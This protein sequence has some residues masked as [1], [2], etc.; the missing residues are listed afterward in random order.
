[1]ATMVLAGSA[2]DAEIMLRE[3]LRGRRLIFE[4]GIDQ[5]FC[6]SARELMLGVLRYECGGN[7][8]LAA[9]AY[10]ALLST[11]IA[12]E[13]VFAYHE[14]DLW[15]RIRLPHSGGW[16]VGRAFAVA[17]AALG[18][19]PFR[20]FDEQSASRY[21]SRILAHGGVPVY[22]LGDL[23]RLV[24]QARA[25]G[26]GDED[27]IID[28]L[29]DGG[30]LGIQLDRP[31][32]RFLCASGSIGSDFLERVLE[33][34]EAAD[35]ALSTSDL[36][37][38]VGLP[39][40]VVQEY[41]RLQSSLDSDTR[42]L[43][44]CPRARL[45]FRFE[46]LTG[47]ELHVPSTERFSPVEVIH[48]DSGRSF[49][50]FSA[51]GGE[52][53]GILVHPSPRWR[54]TYLSSDDG[55][56]HYSGVAGVTEERPVLVF[57][58][59]T[60][61][62][63]GDPRFCPVPSVVV[64]AP[65]LLETGDGNANVVEHYQLRSAGWDGWLAHLVDVNESATLN[66]TLGLDRISLHLGRQSRRSLTVDNEVT[67]VS[68]A[69]GS[70]ILDGP[71]KFSSVPWE[72]GNEP[73]WR[74]VVRL[75]AGIAASVQPA[76][77]ADAF[78]EQMAN[79]LGTKLIPA[80]TLRMLGPM[81][82]S[83]RYSCAIVPGLRLDLPQHSLMPEESTVVG[84]SVAAGGWVMDGFSND[85]KLHA[86]AD[87]ARQTFTVGEG[88]QYLGILLR[89]PIVRWRL[90]SD[91]RV[92]QLDSTVIAA[93]FSAKTDPNIQLIIDLPADSGWVEVE[94]LQGNGGD[95][96]KLQVAAGSMRCVDLS[97]AIS[98]AISDETLYFDVILHCRERSALL[99]RFEES[100]T[101]SLEAVSLSST[102]SGRWLHFRLSDDRRLAG[103]ALRIASMERPWT[104]PI[105]EHLHELGAEGDIACTRLLPGRYTVELVFYDAKGDCHQPEVSSPVLVEIPWPERV[106]DF[107]DPEDEREH[108]LRAVMRS[109]YTMP[110]LQDPNAAASAALFLLGSDRCDSR[111]AQTLLKALAISPDQWL[112]ASD[113]AVALSGSKYVV[114]RS[115][116][117]LMA[118]VLGESKWSRCPEGSATLLR[119]LQCVPDQ[120][121][122]SRE[123]FAATTGARWDV[124][125]TFEDLLG[126]RARHA[127][128]RSLNSVL[129]SLRRIESSALSVNGR[130]R[131]LL[132]VR[133]WWNSGDPQ[134][135]GWIALLAR[136]APSSPAD[137]GLLSPHVRRDCSLAREWLRRGEHPD[138]AAVA[139]LHVASFEAAAHLAF[140]TARTG[141][142]AEFLA[143]VAKTFPEYVETRLAYGL[144]ER[145]QSQ[146]GTISS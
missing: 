53:T 9:S 112:Q 77:T 18:L 113:E 24:H 133:S 45:F 39:D 120:S 116:V 25:R 111:A 78:S 107:G 44:L 118:Y 73:L 96:A 103:R 57:R 71:P 144:R 99:A 64:L 49:A 100:I 12:A 75:G 46:S 35:G 22:C 124:P 6:D 5:S 140:E 59:D 84:I 47:P 102:T 23:F 89:L 109:D 7:Y 63:I 95:S 82:E 85:W 31:I 92:S 87:D 121:E 30:Q 104:R 14:G 13:G 38:E 142:C 114:V 81:G 36:A 55:G 126:S 115:S 137:L 54:V 52:E 62:Q 108:L 32:V 68:T 1:M 123:Q 76:A 138:G 122:W 136:N 86:R 119:L 83:I 43:R 67:F 101:V 80:L 79:L 146:A 48:Q 91:S 21:V 42:V 60:G 33:L 41:R 56:L 132:E 17:V 10:P 131:G 145:I 20:A 26:F 106:E 129:R 11:T 29:R 110:T 8:G 34:P 2:A 88:G 40:Y 37:A 19:E 50:Q 65:T 58:R 15:G 69:D 125:L 70:P 117:R 139:A 141:A 127:T 98:T 93:T 105:I 128:V 61:E 28:L 134:K 66:G 74:I 3:A 72:V 94:C 97:D 130:A 4:I 90:V 51:T 16:E 27:E 143:S 135:Q